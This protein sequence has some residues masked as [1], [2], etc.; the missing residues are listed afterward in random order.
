MA[1]AL[2]AGLSAALAVLALLLLGLWQAGA[3]QQRAVQRRLS[4]EIGPGHGGRR[5]QHWWQL[6]SAPG[7][8]L[9][10]WIDEDGETDRLLLQAGWRSALQR[11]GYFAVQALLPLSVLVLLFGAGLLGELDSG[12]RIVW[13]LILIFASLLAPRFLLKRAARRRRDRIRRETA[14]F[15][16]LLALLFDAGLSLRQALV[17]LVREGEQVLPVLGEEVQVVL[18]QLEAGA[19][20]AEALHTMGRSLDVAELTAVLGVLRQ[21]DRYGG[22]LREPLMEALSVVE[23]RRQLALR[24]TVNG[25]SGRMTVVMVLFFF[26]ALLFFVAG[27]AFLSVIRALAGGD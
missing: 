25:L 9:D 5:E 16:H 2:L 10:A 4:T 26:P 18:R 21:V 6:F 7:R 27:P 15:I 1:W 3:R 23:E 13:S 8:Q 22:E 24:E 20:P 19:D 11:A 14:M 12:Q 17:S